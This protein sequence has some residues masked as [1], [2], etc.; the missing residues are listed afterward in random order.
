MVYSDALTK[1][2]RL[3][4]LQY[5]FWSRPGRA[6]STHEVALALGIAPR[7]ARKYVSELSSTG[8]LPV[9]HER[10]GW[11]LVEG[12]RLEVLP[13]RFQL[14]EAA[15]LFLAARLLAE[16]ADEPNRAV[17][18]ALTRLA[19]VMP[20]E[21]R[22]V[23]G[24]LAERTPTAEGRFVSVFRAF[25][26][27]WA[28]RRVLDVDYEPRTHPGTVLRCGFSPYLLEPVAASR[29]LYAIGRAEPPGELRVLKLERV[30]SAMLTERTFAPPP[31]DQLLDRLDRAWGVWLSDEE[32]VQVRL[33][34][35][36]A[37]AQRVRETRWHPSQRLTGRDDGS[38]E[39]ALT[40]ASAVEL[41]P[42]I[43]GW[44]RH[45]RVLAP[46][47]LAAVVAAEHRA[48]ASRY[49]TEFPAMRSGP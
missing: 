47:D 11:R 9:A 37:V 15:A 41:L 16:E 40:V 44:G 18:D 48:A 27:G 6:V 29:A 2:S 28:L 17:H 7:T 43:V 22:E 34:F 42:W 8:R 13:V 20:A 3:V 4:E 5:L 26:Y 39:L 14:E 35:D 32:P 31:L 21:L 49:E 12:A 33:S 25:A 10:L 19:R 38:V 30:H 45:C 36:P 24:R 1:A 46:A 23:F